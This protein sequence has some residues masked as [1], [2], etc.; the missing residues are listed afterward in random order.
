MSYML[1]K[2][3]IGMYPWSIVA[4]TQNAAQRAKV[5]S[6]PTREVLCIGREMI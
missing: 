4:M 1:L 2:V 5:P 6:R 3:N